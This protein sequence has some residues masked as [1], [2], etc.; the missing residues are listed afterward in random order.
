MPR[1]LLW[2]LAIGALLP[3]TGIAGSDWP[4][5]LHDYARSG[6]TPQSLPLPL[7]LQW[8]YR[9]PVPPELAWEGPRDEPFE[10]HVLRHR[11]DFDNV[12][13]VTAV[14]S[15]V[16][17]G[18][19]V[20][21][22]VYCVDG[23]A[24]TISWRFPTD[25]PVRLV[26][27]VADGKVYFGSDDGYV[28]CVAADNGE[29]IWKQRGGPCDERLLAR[30]R[31]ISRWPIRTGVIVEDQIAYYGAG[32]LPHDQ[33]YLCAVDAGDGTFLWRNDTISQQDAGRNPLSPQG[34]LLCSDERL[35]V[36]SGGA[37]PA[38]FDKRTGRELYQRSHAWRTTAGG[39]VG[40]S[41]ATLADGQIYAS[42]PHHFLALDEKTGKVGFAW[43]TG[44]QLVVADASALVADGERIV[45]LD[46]RA[47]AAATVERQKLRIERKK[48]QSDRKTL[49]AQEYRA[50]ISQID[51]RMAEL[52]DVGLRWQYPA[53]HDAALIACGTTV[54]AGGDGEVIALD[55]QSGELLWRSEV[56]GR[57]AG[58]A[59]AAGRL[60]VS[61]TAGLIYCFT[62]TDEA[63]NTP[64]VATLPSPPVSEP[65]PPDE[66]TEMYAAAAEQ[67]LADTGVERGFCLVVGSEMGRLAFE[68]A[69]RSALQ[70]YAVEPDAEK[71]QA[72]RRALDQAHMHGT[73]ITILQC[74]PDAMPF[75]NY[76]ANL[77]VS[78]TLLLTGQLPGSV[79][80]IARQLKPLG[81]VLH[82]A[83]PPSAPAASQPSITARLTEVVARIERRIAADVRAIER[84]V[85]LRRGPLPGVGQWSHQYA[86][87]ANTMTSQDQH[88]R[89]DLGTL[90]YGDPGPAE[91]INRHDAAAAPLSTAGRMFVQGYRSIRAYDA[92]N[93]LFLWEYQN[94]GA[95]RTGV[96]NNEDTSNLAAS[97]EHVFVVVDDSC[98]VLDAATGVVAARH[99]IPPLDAADD[100]PR[101]WGY[102]AHW[103]G[104]L[105]GTSTV[106][107]DL[108]KSLRRRGLH[109]G[110]ETNALFA[111]D[112]VTG[113]RKWVY[114]G[115]SIEHVTI[116]IGDGRVFFIDSS[117]SSE[118]R[119]A[120]LRQDK[121][122]L[123][124]L[125]PADA[126]QKEAEL[127]QLDVRLAVCLDAYSGELQWS[128][129][130]DVTDC[131]RVGIGGGNLTLMYHDGHVVICGANANG[132]YWRQ[133]LSGQFDRRR[134]VVLDARTGT[135][136]WAK[137]ANYRIRPIIVDDWIIEE[138]WAFALRTGE[139]KQRQHPV[140]GEMADWQFSRPGHHCGPITGAP[141]M[142]FFR[143]GFT[144]YYDLHADS[145]TTHFA[146]HRP[147]CWVNAIPA[148]GLLLV[149]EASAGC[150]CAFSLT[151]TVVLEPRD[152]RESWRLFSAGGDVTPVRHLAVN[153]GAPGDRRDREGTLWIAHPRPA[154]VGRLEFVLDLPVKLAPGGG[155]Y[156]HNDASLTVEN[157]VAPWVFTSG[158]RG[159][160][161]SDFPLRGKNDPPAE[162]SVRLLFAALEKEGTF[163][164]P[165]DIKLQGTLV[166]ENIDVVT[167]AGGP[168]RTWECVVEA[169]TVSDSLVLELVPSGEATLPEQLPCLAGI[170]IRR[171]ADK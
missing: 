94:P 25:G 123:A 10:G 88:L 70:I 113:E 37:L 50:Q 17:F 47:H 8:T 105:Y 135:T 96:F 100:L 122:E 33:V 26:P 9:S 49:D 102:V 107:K 160:G 38:A 104:L 145:G 54:V 42:G 162:Y 142:L 22:Q 81:G 146:G 11:V 46:R 53:P 95:M 138:P 121:S 23:V 62:A 61:T 4:T 56:D 109:V 97:E 99:A 128:R 165:F 15:R 69:R 170:E 91:M 55:V 103:N 84:G 116:A 7:R 151:A 136:L 32:V 87:A 68:L 86:D 129:P 41:K 167:E 159:L 48:L 157:A 156:Q 28:Y 130:V 27:T 140:T 73:R 60:F 3:S 166:A 92:Y 31:M 51:A 30:G 6:F 12:L 158:V 124:A 72:A 101:I 63:T 43:V 44:R 127:K 137:D 76:F 125:G 16:F 161:R 19:S 153:F 20:D 39:A 163:S 139:A 164:L 144:G 155:Y 111:L 78:D 132:H 168:G 169:V 108:E 120:L 58:L 119:E 106:P 71:A 36:P 150:V 83:V 66:L 18:S 65:Y 93:G 82:V 152:E 79:D 171:I 112:V 89:G 77:V 13:H 80:Q 134:L 85:L 59:M 52:S 118:Q 115:G 57:A 126:E 24:G 148:N 110:K 90:W 131:S 75:S 21:H 45:A 133:F 67:I 154:T 1:L 29:L 141:H 14:G 149:P 114:Q 147:G 2:L 5:Y 35:I 40:G 34:Y 98:T 74:D 64:A 143:S 117:I